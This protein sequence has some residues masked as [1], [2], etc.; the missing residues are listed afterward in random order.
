MSI[1]DT[2]VN[3]LI[4]RLRLHLG[5]FTAPYRYLNEWLETSLLVAVEALMPR[6]NYKYILSETNQVSRNANHVYAFASPPIIQRGDVWPIVV[7]A[8]III[9]EG[10]L[11]NQSWNF[12]A[13]RDAEIQYSNLEESRS[14]DASLRRDIALLENMLPERTKRL[15]QPRKGHLPGYLGN[16]YEHD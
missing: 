1:T 5:D 15:A 7:Q 12:A 10:S 11:E 9:K 14:K 8:S 16:P 3:Y 4:E 13:W 6:W 2:N